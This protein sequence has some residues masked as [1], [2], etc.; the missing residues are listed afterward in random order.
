M[1]RAA[2]HVGL[3][4]LAVPWY[5]RALEADVPLPWR[6]KDESSEFTLTFAPQ[7]Q[8]HL[9]SSLWCKQLAEIH[10]L[11]NTFQWTKDASFKWIDKDECK[12][13][14]W[15]MLQNACSSLRRSF[16]STMKGNSLG[17]SGGDCR[18]STSQCGP[19]TRDCL[20]S[21]YPSSE[22]WG[23]WACKGS[24]GQ[25][26]HNLMYIIISCGQSF[27]M[28]G[29]VQQLAS[30]IAAFFSLAFQEIMVLPMLKFDMLRSWRLCDEILTH[31]LLPSRPAFISSGCFN[32]KYRRS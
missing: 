31:P 17:A 10:C 9:F 16:K 8:G 21:G 18:T 32:V 6:P 7:I 2:H 29:T 11:S 28:T 24:D 27:L 12:A 23:R 4:H 13:T 25:A 1:G 30:H 14:L 15:G 5:Y 19:Q 3:L 22:L 20:Q 26:P